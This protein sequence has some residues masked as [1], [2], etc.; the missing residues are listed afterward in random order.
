MCHEIEAKLKVDSLEKVEHKLQQLEAEFHDKMLQTDI[1]FDDEHSNLTKTDTCLRIRKQTNGSEEKIFLTYKGPKAQVNYKKR[2]EIEFEV[3]D[4][5]AVEKLLNAL[6]Y[7]KALIV[8]KERHL[9]HLG[10]CEVLLD[11]LPQLGTFV[12]I[13]GPDE[14]EIEIVQKELELDC[15]PHIHESYAHLIEKKNKVK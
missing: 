11:D 7:K 13:E 8:E 1:Y 5:S 9:W 2:R 6:G 12:E 15:L 3:P 4:A 10:Q 14:N